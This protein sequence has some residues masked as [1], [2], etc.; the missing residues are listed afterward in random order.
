MTRHI[1]LN[2]IIFPG[3][4]SI[5]VFHGLYQ[6]S[7]IPSHEH[8]SLEISQ[9]VSLPAHVSMEALE[10]VQVPEKCMKFNILSFLKVLK[11]AFLYLGSRM[12]K[13]HIFA[14]F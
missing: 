13:A 3:H 4:D 1:L 8:S 12:N 11:E 2:L 5:L 9:L 7:Q 10:E 14:S 6:T